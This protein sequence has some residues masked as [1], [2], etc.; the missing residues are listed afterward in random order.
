[1]KKVLLKNLQMIYLKVIKN[2]PILKQTVKIVIVKIEVI[3][4]NIIVATKQNQ[5]QIILKILI[6]N[7]LLLNLIKRNLQQKLMIKVKM[8]M[9]KKITIILLI[10]M[11]KKMKK[12]KKLK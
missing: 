11:K 10:K 7:H 3:I 12:L 8:K 1:M 5:L 9:K 6:L 2:K 4:N